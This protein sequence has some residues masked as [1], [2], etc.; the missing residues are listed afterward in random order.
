MGQRP[1]PGDDRNDVPETDRV[2]FTGFKI[3]EATADRFRQFGQAGHLTGPSDLDEVEGDCVRPGL[4]APPRSLEGRSDIDAAM[5]EALRVLD[6]EPAIPKWT[7]QSE[8]S[9]GA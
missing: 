4:P 9:F 8:S 7:P 5:V 1:S 3:I 6:H 2:A